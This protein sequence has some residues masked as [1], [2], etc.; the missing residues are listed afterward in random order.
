[1]R[2]YATLL[3]FCA[4]AC[5]PQSD[6][7]EAAI[8]TAAEIPLLL[9]GQ[10]AV[11]EQSCD[12]EIRTVIGPREISFGGVALPV[13]DVRQRGPDH[14]YRIDLAAAGPARAI[15]ISMSRDGRHITYRTSGDGSQSVRYIRCP[16]KV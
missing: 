3:M 14:D 8:K 16:A 11:D 6:S 2:R 5:Q 15:D 13:V 4:A 12:A 1:M 7:Q 10:W 9:Q